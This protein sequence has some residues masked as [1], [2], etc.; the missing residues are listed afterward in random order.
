MFAGVRAVADGAVHVDHL[1]G[2]AGLRGQA[3]VQGFEGGA[4]FDDVARMLGRQAG[5]RGAAAGFDAHQ[6]GGGQ[7]AQRLAHRN[8][9]N[10]HFLG[11]VALDQAFALG[12]GATQDAF[13]QGFLH[14]GEQRRMLAA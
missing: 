8:A 14:Q 3:G 7:G 10:A 4:H 13:A 6:A 1:L 5:H 2:V 11:Q 9:R 12:I